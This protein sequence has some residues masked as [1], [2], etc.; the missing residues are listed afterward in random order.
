MAL[1]YFMSAFM[2][3]GAGPRGLPPAPP[4]N[5]SS[6]LLQAQTNCLGAHK[7]RGGGKIARGRGGEAG[8]VG[9]DHSVPAFAPLHL[10]K[11]RHLSLRQAEKVGIL[12]QSHLLVAAAGSS[13]PLNICT[14]RSHLALNFVAHAHCW[15]QH[16]CALGQQRPW[17]NSITSLG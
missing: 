1:G 15:P 6:F 10:F 8:Q 4:C 17:H 5:I 9:M 11:K 7:G 3:S 2:P 13:S 16:H 14:L 12:S